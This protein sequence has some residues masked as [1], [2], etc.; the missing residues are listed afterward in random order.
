MIALG[1]ITEA[2][3]LD[4]EALGNVILEWA[5]KQAEDIAQRKLA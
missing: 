2:R 1:A 4:P 3:A 5:I